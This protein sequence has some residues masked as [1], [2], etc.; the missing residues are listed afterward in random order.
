MLE[1]PCRNLF[2]FSVAQVFF[3]FL[4]NFSRS[5][6]LHRMVFLMR[7][8]ADPV[9]SG[10]FTKIKVLLYTC[11]WSWLSIVLV[12]VVMYTMFCVMHFGLPFLNV[13]N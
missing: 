6:A 8:T 3:F 1:C 4:L 2:S 10:S 12:L 13:L 7:V 11:G 5:Y 9:I